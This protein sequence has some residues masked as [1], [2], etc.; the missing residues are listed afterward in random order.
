[1]YVVNSRFILALDPTNTIGEICYTKM[2]VVEKAQ[3]H[4]PTRRDN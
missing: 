2:A 1:M 3:I 4:G